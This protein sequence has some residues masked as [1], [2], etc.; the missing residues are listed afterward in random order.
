VIYQM[1]I[2]QTAEP[3]IGG[4][5]TLP[6]RIRTR[7]EVSGYVD[8]YSEGIAEVTVWEDGDLVFKQTALPPSLPNFDIMVTEDTPI[9][10][11]FDVSLHASC[12]AMSDRD[13][14]ASDC[15]A[16]VD[17]EFDFDQAAFDAAMGEDSFPLDDF[18]EA[19]LSANL[20]VLGDI[21]CDGNLTPIDASVVLGLF[22][23]NIVD[24]DLPP[25][26]N[27]PAHRLAVSDWDLNGAI[28]PIDASVTLTVFVGTIAEC[29]TPLGQSIP[30][31]CPLPL[32][33]SLSGPAAGR[34]P[35]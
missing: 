1:R 15:Q 23:G 17:P 4:L 2:Q 33:A 25:P 29:D 9:D 19:E 14:L 5:F 27:D 11:V 30:G 12:W 35:R 26:C 13:L 22:V 20:A 10:T 18:Y 28:N 24:S 21:D 8:N 16:L 3:P 6:L 31:L 32:A 34:D 7:G